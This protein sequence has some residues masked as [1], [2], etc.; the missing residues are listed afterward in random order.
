M[1]THMKKVLESSKKKLEANL[2]LRNSGYLKHGPCGP[3][4]SPVCVRLTGEGSV[5]IRMASVSETIREIQP[6]CYISEAHSDPDSE[7]ESVGHKIY[8]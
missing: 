7:L 3:P 5:C 2:L 6:Y 1:F 4:N 8:N